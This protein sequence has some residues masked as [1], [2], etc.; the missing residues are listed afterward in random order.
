MLQ[1]SQNRNFI[2]YFVGNDTNEKT[3]QNLTGQN[4]FLDIKMSPN[5]IRIFHT[6]YVLQPQWNYIRNG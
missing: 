4:I 5:F 3:G 6:T 2:T 1:R